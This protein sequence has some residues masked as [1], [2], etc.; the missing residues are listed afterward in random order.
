MHPCGDGFA[1]CLY[2]DRRLTNAI[3]LVYCLNGQHKEYHLLVHHVWDDIDQTR[4]LSQAVITIA[5]AR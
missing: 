5:V 3:Y 2:T 1:R 4:A